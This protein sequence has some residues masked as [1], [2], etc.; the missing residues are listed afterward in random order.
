MREIWRD[1]KDYEGL[2]KVSNF[3]RV[4]SL[5]YRNT[6]REKILQLNKTKNGYIRVC[7][8]KDGKTKAFLV[9]RLVALAFID[10][11]DLKPCVNHID[12]DKTNNSVE[13][14]EFV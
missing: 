14:L 4:K 9:H 11:I 7:L 8:W 6:G 13:N 5:N 2:Y 3:G 10:N 1:I 12:E